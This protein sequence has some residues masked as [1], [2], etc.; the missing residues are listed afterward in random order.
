MTVAGL[1]SALSVAV[2]VTE[3]VFIPAAGM[4]I[5]AGLAFSKTSL[6]IIRYRAR[7][8]ATGWHQARLGI[9][10]RL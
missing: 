4:I 7:K 9:D 1:K 2:K 5:A 6:W 3:S 10:R 8:S